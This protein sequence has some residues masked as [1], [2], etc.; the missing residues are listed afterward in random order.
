MHI[1][2]T[3]FGDLMGDSQGPNEA[4]MGVMTSSVG[5]MT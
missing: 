1:I 4:C 5:G 3:L 2:I